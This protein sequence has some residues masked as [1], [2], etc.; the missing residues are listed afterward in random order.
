M[1][2]REQA[3]DLQVKLQSLNSCDIFSTGV[4]KGK[5]GY[6]VK[7]VLRSPAPYGVP[8]SLDGVP[9]VAL[10]LDEAAKEF[11]EKK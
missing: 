2:S 3:K 1:T 9:I 11:A 6:F 7:L 8:E 4:E 10:T 5:D